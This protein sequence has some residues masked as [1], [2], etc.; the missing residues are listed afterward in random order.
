MLSYPRL[1]NT[2]PVIS[3]QTFYFRKPD[4]QKVSAQEKQSKSLSLHVAYW[5]M[6][7]EGWKDTL[8]MI[9]S[10]PLK[11]LMGKRRRIKELWLAQDQR[12]N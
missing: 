2:Q 12:K 6:E 7:C 11:L 4:F 5:I 9:P 10:E 8:K 1:I 3:E